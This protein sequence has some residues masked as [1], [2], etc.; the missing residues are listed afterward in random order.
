[1]ER[2]LAFLKRHAFLLAGLGL[3]LL[4]IAALLVA[5]AVPRFLVDDPRHALLYAVDG[6]HYRPDDRRVQDLKVEQ[7]RLV[8]G[9]NLI[10]EPNYQPRRRAFRADP[11][12]GELVELR[13][14]EPE[15]G[16]L[17][18]H[19]GRV[20]YAIEGLGDA[21]V[22]TQPVSPD[23]WSFS[24][25]YRGGGGLFGELFFSGASGLRVRIEKN[26]RALD[27]P[28]T[29]VGGYGAVY[30]LGWVVPEEDGK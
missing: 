4:L 8:V 11:S 20:Q 2:E 16:E 30:F 10:D 9:W 25:V 3:P 7:G 12:S 18:R 26:G 21:R 17:E 1:M 29:E 23:G 6:E 22:D 13:V 19:G 5:R 15:V 24:S 14:P 28:R 27:V